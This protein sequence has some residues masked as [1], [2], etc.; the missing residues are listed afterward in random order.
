MESVQMSYALFAFYDDFYLFVSVS[1]INS[2]NAK[3]SYQFAA[4]EPFFG[5]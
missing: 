1:K 2:V 5:K 3:S 4:F